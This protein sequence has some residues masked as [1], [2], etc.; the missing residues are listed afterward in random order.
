MRRASMV[1]VE[2]KNISKP[3]VKRP[4]ANLQLGK[5]AVPP[6]DPPTACIWIPLG[7]SGPAA[8]LK[9]N[10]VESTMNSL[11]GAK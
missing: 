2:E 3:A 9:S 6:N 1:G 10:F 11:C 5:E 8:K 4:A 7:P